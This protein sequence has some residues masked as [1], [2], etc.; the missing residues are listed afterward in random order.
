MNNN[1]RALVWQ[2][3]RRRAIFLPVMVLLAFLLLH[4]GLKGLVRTE[5]FGEA[6]DYVWRLLMDA[7][8]DAWARAFRSVL[9]VFVRHLDIA[10]YASVMLGALLWSATFGGGIRWLERKMPSHFSDSITPHEQACAR[11]YAVALALF[12]TMVAVASVSAWIVF[13]ANDAYVANVF[14]TAL[15]DGTTTIREILAF[16]LGVPLIVG[17]L[18]WG[19]LCAMT[20]KGI[21]TLC[22]FFVV[23]A[24]MVANSLLIPK[25]PD[26]EETIRS[27]AFMLIVFPSIVL[28]IETMYALEKNWRQGALSKATFRRLMAIWAT[29]ALIVY[30]FRTGEFMLEFVF[31]GVALGAM[32]IFPYTCLLD[33]RQ[34]ER[35]AG[36]AGQPLPC[37][38]DAPKPSTTGRVLI[39]AVLLFLAW[40]RW[41]AEFALDKKMRAEGLPVTLE[42]LD[43]CYKHVEPSQNV[44]LAYLEVVELKDK[45]DE[46]RESRDWGDIFIEGGGELNEDDSIPSEVWEETYAYWKESQ[47]EIVPKLKE[48]AQTNYAGSRYP[49]ELS[50]GI[51]MELPHLS[52]LRNLARTLSLDAFVASVEKRPHDAV[53][54]ILAQSAISQSLADEPVLISQLV[55]TAIL[56]MGHYVFEDTLCRTE[57]SDA[58]LARMQIAFDTAL[59]PVDEEMM[60]GMPLITE[61]GMIAD[62]L[63]KR[64]IGNRDR[65]HIP[66]GA[67]REIALDMTLV[68]LYISLIHYQNLFVKPESLTGLEQFAQAKQ[69]NG[70]PPYRTYSWMFLESNLSAGLAAMPRCIEAEVRIRTQLSM[71]STAIAVERY[72]IKYGRWPESLEALVPEFVPEIPEDPYQEG[73]PLKYIIRDN[74]DF[75]VYSAWMNGIDDGGVLGPDGKKYS[76]RECLD[77]LFTVKPPERRTSVIADPLPPEEPATNEESQSAPRSGRGQGRRR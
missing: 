28:S 17:I 60:M 33:K 72:R 54:S 53:E 18:A 34:H 23:A 26:G 7:R 47:K 1:F 38:E 44:A 51:D 10:L 13:S 5:L 11:L 12:G 68:E 3:F 62:S 70:A 61:R 64:E 24:L 69:D 35:E 65:R 42:E 77:L 16:A 37:Q 4:F 75:I 74:G 20:G 55:R 19:M 43:A 8:M 41:P 25:N 31:M 71:A 22:F 46:D 63:R 29:T 56:G 9:D 45:L 67:I 52:R 66:V 40:I 21:R 48:I 2:E 6:Y 32:I 58:D 76:I 27:T 36:S 15:A 50:K 39:V 14:S 59:P 30:P 57:I 49:L 73:Y